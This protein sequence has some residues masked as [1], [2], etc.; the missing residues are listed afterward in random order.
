VR[1]LTRQTLGGLAYLHDKGILHRDLKADNIL[2]Q[3]ASDRSTGDILQVDG[4]REFATLASKIL[5]DV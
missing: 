2:A 3:T 5:H 4:D 1:S